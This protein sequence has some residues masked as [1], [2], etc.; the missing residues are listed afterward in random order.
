MAVK[1]K[2]IAEIGI[3]HNGSMD[4]CKQ[5]IKECKDVGFDYVKFQKR[6]PEICVPMAQ[7]SKMRDTPWGQMTYFDY[8]LRI[9]FGKAEYDEIDRYCHELGIEWFASAFDA[10]SIRFLA[11]YLTTGK[12]F[13]KIVKLG[14]ANSI[15]YDL[16][17]VARQEFEPHTIMI[18]L[19]MRTESEVRE[20]IKQANPHVILHTV[21]TYPTDNKFLFLNYIHRLKRLYPTLEIGYSGHEAGVAPTL[22]AAGM[23]C[24]WFER[25]V[26]LDKAMWGT[27]QKASLNVPEMRE[28]LSGLR[29]IEAALSI[30]CVERYLLPGEAEK[31]VVTAIVDEIWSQQPGQSSAGTISNKRKKSGVVCMIPARRTSKHIPGHNLRLL[32]GKPLVAWTIEAALSSAVFDGVY[33]S[34]DDEEIGQVARS[35]GASVHMRSPAASAETALLEDVARDFESHAGVEYETLII[36]NPTNPL[37]GAGLIQDAVKRFSSA[38]SARF[39]VCVRKQAQCTWVKTGSDG[40][41]FV[42][43]LTGYGPKHNPLNKPRM[44]SVVPTLCETGAIYGVRRGQYVGHT[45]DEGN[46][47][48]LEVDEFQAVDMGH[49]LSFVV[50]EAL[51]DAVA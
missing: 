26:T 14:S 43:P 34:T 4:I 50:A 25:H 16:C 36:L 46:T 35:Y 45:C 1:L 8:K 19:G 44:S 21:S 27:D 42:K 15:D 37:R 20:S 39:L 40:D 33:V 13:A 17:K 49:N 32:K 31:R 38:P 24:T 28:L 9:E 10:P 29:E 11:D 47:V 7:R 18:S 2:T 41:D 12:S 6:D 5:L 30:P 23:G 3:N 51:A 22:A 48:M